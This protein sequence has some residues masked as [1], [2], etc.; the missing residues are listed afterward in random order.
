MSKLT[1]L[2]VKAL[3]EAGRYSDGQG[4]MLLVKP[5]G[6]RSWLLRMQVGGA[7]RDIGLGSAAVVSLSEARERASEARKQL[8]GGIDPVEAKRASRRILAAV[9][10]F[11]EAAKVAHAERKAGW[12]NGKHQDQWLSSLEAYAFPAIGDTPVDKVSGPAVRDLLLAIWLDKPETARRVLQRI[13]TVLDWAHSNGHRPTEAPMRSI[14]KGLPRQPKKDRHFAALPYPDVPALMDK[15]GEADTA[16]RLGLRFLILTAARSGELRGATWEEID[17]GEAT[18][19]VPSSRMKA[20]KEHVVPLSAAAIGV[21][22]IAARMRTGIAREPVFSG[23]GGKVMS[24]MT[25]AKALKTA[26]GGRWTVH[27]LRSSFRDWAAETTDTQGEI[28]EAALAHT[29]ANKVEAAYRRTNYLE[30]RRGLMDAWA[31]YICHAIKA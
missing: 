28:V 9:P 24:D 11:R 7:R 31:G 22:T 10:T 25:L 2:K 30:K 12:A 8:R 27:G 19:T 6:S 18:W 13:G 14:G 5:S 23:Q 3:R 21:L 16:G 17:V 4:L 1:A 29:I 26:T 15:L 20:K